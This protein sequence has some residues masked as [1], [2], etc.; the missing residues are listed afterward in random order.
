MLIELLTGLALAV[1]VPMALKSAEPGSSIRPALAGAL[2]S[3]TF[4]MDEGLIAAVVA[5]VWTGAVGWVVLLEAKR[6]PNILSVR[7]VLHLWPLLHLSLGTVW[8]VLSRYGAR[9]LGFSS[10]IVALTAVHFHYAGFIAPTLISKLEQQLSSPPRNLRGLVQLTRVGVLVATPLTA[11]G[12][13]FAPVF[14]A[15][16][17][18]LFGIGLGISSSVTWVVTR[19]LTD[20]VGVVLLRLSASSVLV[21]MVLAV[22]YAAGQW[23]GTRAPTIETMSRTHGLLNALGYSLAGLIGWR[24]IERDSS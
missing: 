1:L 23:L 4:L 22:F 13:T 19:S 5:L 9:P 20:R 10:T 16:G 2:S 15:L 7:A 14:G 17:A 24:M 11:A 6:T 12:I 21:A 3:T 8:L 18:S